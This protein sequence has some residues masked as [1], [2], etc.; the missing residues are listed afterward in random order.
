MSN[1]Q[2]FSCE[3]KHLNQTTI[4]SLA[5][6]CRM[7]VEMTFVIICSVL[8]YSAMY[9]SKCGIMLHLLAVLI[10]EPLNYG[11][12]D[13]KR[14][15]ETLV[16]LMHANHT[17]LIMWSVGVLF[18]RHPVTLNPGIMIINANYGLG[19]VSESQRYV[20]NKV[21]ETSIYCYNNLN[22][23]CQ[24]LWVSCCELLKPVLN[25]WIFF[26]CFQNESWVWNEQLELIIDAA[27]WSDGNQIIN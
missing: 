25:K 17:A 12:V 18:T 6:N 13:C 15:F 11:T 24:K 4:K 5:V 14:S 2:P 20:S 16:M 27:T 8:F 26:R 22:K 23:K 3:P 19:E 21:I 7:K 10:A 9:F 1:T